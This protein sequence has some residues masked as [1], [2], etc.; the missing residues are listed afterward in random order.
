MRNR[1]YLI[2]AA[3][4]VLSFSAILFVS[5][6]YEVLCNSVLITCTK[7]GSLWFFRGALY[8]ALVALFLTSLRYR[9]PVAAAWLFAGLL[10]HSVLL[11][12]G[13][14]LCAICLM[15]ALTH[16]ILVVLYFL[17]CANADHVND[18]A[19]KVIQVVAVI[20]ILMAVSLLPKAIGQPLESVPLATSQVAEAGSSLQVSTPEGATA[21]INLSQ[22]PT[23]FFSTWCPHC[24]ELLKELKNAD[25]IPHLVL[26]YLQEGDLD[27][28]REK[29]GENGL[30]GLD[31]YFTASPPGGIEGVPSLVW[32]ENDEIKHVEGNVAILRKLNIPK[33]LGKATVPNHADAGAINADLAADIMNGTLIKSGEVFSF[34]Q[35]V[36]ERKVSRGFVEGRSVIQD[37]Y[38]ELEVVPDVGGGVCRSSTALHLAVLNAGLKVLERNPHGLPVA[39]AKEGTDA[40]VAYGYLDYKF[41]NNTAQTIRIEVEIQGEELTVELWGYY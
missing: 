41:R 40:A 17:P 36:G 35:V 12:L 18:I 23:L 37:V 19:K 10:V 31:Y 11:A 4:L 33:L 9:S 24:W 21:N 28:A 34:N 3:Y 14:Y 25:N 5:Q 30:S 38:G 27:E 2:S 1:S 15:F 29:L 6:D 32:I 20:A 7:G 8:Y 26:T 22:K 39:Y 16:T 13:G